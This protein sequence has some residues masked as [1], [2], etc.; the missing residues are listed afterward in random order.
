VA[1]YTL[2]L[3][4]EERMRYRMMA[5][6]AQTNEAD[7][8]ASAGIV[9]GASVA[10]VGCGPG[11]MLTAL[12]A[13]VGV[14]G[15][16]DGVDA[17]PGA[18]A[19]A[20]VEVADHPHARVAV[21]RAEATGLPEASYDVVVCRHV[22][23]HNG[24]QEQQI[25]N[26]LASRT[27]PGGTVY[28]VDVVASMLALEPPIASVEALSERYI[29]L[30]ARR[31]NDLRTGMRLGNLLQAAG[32]AVEY[33]GSRSPVM[34]LP[35]GVRP[36]AWAARDQLLREGLATQRELDEWAAVFAELDQQTQRPWLFPATFVAIGRRAE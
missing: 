16:V 2:A 17:D 26:H 34:L 9:A 25:V 29:Q 15:R 8:W 23:A 7:L 32:L 14:A 11:A 33:F 12:A 24:Q 31:G 18:V 20:T 21:G 30:H 22:L 6:Y 28:L 36:P 5:T 10:D 27:R 19:D 3:S 4:E 1:D 35:P 13:T